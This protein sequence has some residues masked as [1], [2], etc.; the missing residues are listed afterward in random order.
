MKVLGIDPGPERTAFVLWVSDTAEILTMGI[1]PSADVSV[2]IPQVSAELTAIEFM[3][4]HGMPVGKETFDTTYW[5]GEYR[6]ICR[7]AG[8]PL[9]PVFRSKV[10]LHHCHSARASDANVHQALLDRFGIMRN[11]K[12]SKGTKK[13]PGGL[14]GVKKDIWSALAI[15]V[16]AAEKDKT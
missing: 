5:I 12:M 14:F 2:L 11:G 9:L 7:V 3:E 1:I 16:Y 10:K 6:Y 8:L 4:C 15:A 13:N